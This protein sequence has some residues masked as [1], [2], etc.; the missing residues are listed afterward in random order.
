MASSTKWQLKCN[1]LKRVDPPL[2]ANWKSGDHRPACRHSKGSE[3]RVFVTSFQ[4]VPAY[5]NN[6][7]KISADILQKTQ[8]FHFIN[9]NPFMLCTELLTVYCGSL[10]IILWA[11]W[12]VVNVKA[13]GMYRYH[14]VLKRLTSLMCNC[15]NVYVILCLYSNMFC[16]VTRHNTFSYSNGAGNA[17]KHILDMKL[18]SGLYPGE[19]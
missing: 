7:F 17:Q 8:C 5:R 15:R 13:G 6:V 19:F 1:K 16:P 4:N 12:S 10:R 3:C 2:T 9:I 14:C 11:N 18:L